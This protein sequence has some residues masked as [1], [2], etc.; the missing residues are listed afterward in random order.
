MVRYFILLGAALAIYPDAGLSAETDP[1][2]LVEQAKALL[3]GRNNVPQIVHLLAEAI[4]DFRSRRDESLNYAEALEMFA[5]LARVSHSGPG[6]SASDAVDLA[7]QIC[8]LHTDS[9]SP[10]LALAL[11]LEA[12]TADRKNRE[13]LLSQAFQIRGTLVS[14]ISP[15]VPLDLRLPITTSKTK[16]VKYPRVSKKIEPEYPDLAR[17]LGLECSGVVLDAVIDITGVPGQFHLLRGCGYGFDEKAAA[18]IRQW[19]FKPAVD[20]SGQP[21][22]FRATV[23]VNFRLL[24]PQ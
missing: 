7:R 24:S 14:Q 11:E 20:P 4:E 2:A 1:V 17:H 5:L 13:L 19:R 12:T 15:E 18:A 9:N 23:G 21:V 8:E 16:G 3:P 10:I 6:F 22:A